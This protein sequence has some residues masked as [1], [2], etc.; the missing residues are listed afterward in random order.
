M[1]GGGG[2]VRGSAAGGAGVACFGSSAA[3]P[4]ATSH[5]QVSI[6]TILTARSL[7]SEADAGGE[8]AE[9]CTAP[10]RRP[11]PRPAGQLGEVVAEPLGRGPQ[12]RAPALGSAAG[13]AATFAARRFRA[14]PA[15]LR[16]GVESRASRRRREAGETSSRADRAGVV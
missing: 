14:L 10:A 1:V 11:R 15:T 6:G 4:A 2:G 16:A 7:E 13:R 9:Q 5:D 12:R 3:A 8:G